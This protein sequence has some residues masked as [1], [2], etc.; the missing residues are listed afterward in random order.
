MRSHFGSE[1]NVIVSFFL[2]VQKMKKS[3]NC[4]NK[5]LLWQISSQVTV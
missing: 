3:E 4:L 2:M 5:I 1:I